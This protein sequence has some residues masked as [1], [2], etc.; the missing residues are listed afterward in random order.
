MFDRKIEM[1]REAG[2]IKYW[3]SKY[4]RRMDDKVPTK[5]KKLNVHNILAIIQIAAVMYLVAFV[6]FLL[7]IVSYEYTRIRNCLDYFTY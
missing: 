5:L 7:E 3:T 2:L 1:F 6:I 4:R